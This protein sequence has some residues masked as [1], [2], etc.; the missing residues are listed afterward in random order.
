MRRSRK[1]FAAVST[2]RL[3]ASS[4][5]TVLTPTTSCKLRSPCLSPSK[6]PE[7]RVFAKRLGHEHSVRSWP[8]QQGFAPAPAWGVNAAPGKRAPLFEKC[9]TWIFFG[10]FRFSVNCTDAGKFILR[11][12]VHDRH[13]LPLDIAGFL[14]TLEE[15]ILVIIIGRLGAIEVANFGT[16]RPT[17]ADPSR[18]R[19]RSRIP[20]LAGS[21]DPASLVGRRCW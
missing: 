19:S 12:P 11:I 18:S 16:R 5:D 3:A 13:V 8:W 20:V 2:A 21:N 1:D 14:Q 17:C 9:R 6:P 4:L 7:M 10:T 15:W